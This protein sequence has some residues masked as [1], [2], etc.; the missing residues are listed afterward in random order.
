MTLIVVASARRN[1]N[2]MQAARQ[3]QAELG[4]D[5][6]DLLDLNIGPFRYDQDYPESDDF[7]DFIEV[8]LLK[9]SSVVFA[10]PV[11]WYSMSGGMKTFFDRMSDLLKSRKELGRQL[12]GK[13]MSILSCSGDDEVFPS[14][15]LPFRLS[16]DYLGMTYGKEWHAW[17]DE[18]GLHLNECRKPEKTKA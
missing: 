16:A 6:V 12:R 17:V 3:L 1:G 4:A 7:L 9:Y 5:V 18:D 2:T 8:K 10:S 14:F 15:F 13:E 11:Y